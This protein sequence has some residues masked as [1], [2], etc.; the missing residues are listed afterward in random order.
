MRMRVDGNAARRVPRRVLT[1][2]VGTT[3]C[4]A[5][6]GAVAAVLRPARVTRVPGAPLSLMGLAHLG[7]SVVPVVSLARL[8][9][10]GRAHV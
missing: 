4:A 8:M 10:I 5:D 9:E 1:F 3:D 2:R 6:A 7:G